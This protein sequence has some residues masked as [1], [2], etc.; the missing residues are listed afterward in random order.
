MRTILPRA[1]RVV[2]ATGPSG[3]VVAAAERVPEDV[4][5][6]G[7]AEPLPVDERRSGSAP[8][9]IL[10]SSSSASAAERLS[11]ERDRRHRAPEAQYVFCW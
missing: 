7:R 5:G 11:K 1:R 2:L 8:A 3:P 10:A 4:A 9:Q 6:D